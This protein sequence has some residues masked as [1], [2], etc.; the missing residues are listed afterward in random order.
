MTRAGPI[1]VVFSGA[2]TIP[3][4]RL[5]RPG[6][7]HCFAVWCD[8]QRWLTYD[9]MAHGTHIGVHDLPPRFDMAA[10][11]RAAGLRVASVRPYARPERPRPAPLAPFT[12]VE[13]VKRLIGLRH[14]RVLTPWQLWRHLARPGAHAHASPSTAIPTKGHI[15]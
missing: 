6:F 14:R 15:R 9:P 13:A 3:W 8:G 1:L 11:Y 2:T 5:L 12:C 10:W 7:R 4:L